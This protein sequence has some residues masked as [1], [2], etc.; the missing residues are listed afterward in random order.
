MTR[1]QD[2][3]EVAL[4]A[5]ATR[6]C[7]VL[8]RHESVANLRWARSTL[9]TNGETD[10]L[11]V[12]VIALVEVPG[13]VAA[14]SVSANAVTVDRMAELVRA[15]EEAARREGPAD[16]AA[17]LAAGIE[18]SH[19]WAEAPVR[20]TSADLADLAPRLGDVFGAAVSDG[21]ELFGY[22]E[23][24]APT[25]YLGTS[26]GTRLRFAESTSRL[27]QTAKSHART[28]SAW[29]GRSGTGFPGADLEGMD[30]ELRR[31]LAWQ[32]TRVD[33]APGRHAALLTPSAVADLM[34][35]LY[36]SSAA[37][38][39]AQ[40]Q[41][42]WSAA[43]GTRRHETVADPRVTLLSDPSWPGLETVPFVTATASSAVTS[44]FDNGLP[45]GAVRWIDRGVLAHLASTRHTA[46]L[47]GVDHRPMVDNLVLQVDGAEG[48]LEDLIART[49]DALL[50]TCLWYNR[51]VDP[52]TLLLT[53]LTRDGVYVVR[54]GEVV[55][56]ASNFRF[57]DSP[58]DVLTRIAD[59]GVSSPTLAREMADYFPRA[60]MPPLL[61]RDYNFSTVS[62]AS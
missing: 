31:G 50:V 59:A 8:A 35:D 55:G 9:T 48:G 39:A 11:S 42:V 49:D 21:I 53:G 54:G 6:G 62:Q 32:A 15:A 61:V 41:S 46:A 24:S 37:R 4:A 45:V 17:D 43:G 16:D 10:G 14:G 34:I 7:I 47:A 22:A 33:V 56:A 25:I 60:S 26:T 3:V 52:Q 27:E 40:G 23:L 58:V 30:A 36:W 38:D 44:V 2:L 18:A 19:D 5:S 12:T 1:P 57:N 20:A 13:G 51:V 28:R 29:A